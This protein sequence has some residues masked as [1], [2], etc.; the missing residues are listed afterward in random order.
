[1]TVSMAGND[2]RPAA[3]VWVNERP[4][5]NHQRGGTDNR[6]EIKKTGQKTTKSS[7]SVVEKTDAKLQGNGIFAEQIMNQI[8]DFSCPQ[9]SLFPP[10]IQY[11]LGIMTERLKI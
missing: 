9:M 5:H 7:I 2:L 11:P 8:K 6:E 1:M 4:D 3:W 10:F